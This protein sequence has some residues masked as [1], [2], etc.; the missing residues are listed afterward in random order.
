MTSQGYKR[1]QGAYLGPEIFDKFLSSE[2]RRFVRFADP[3][4]DECF[5]DSLGDIIPEML[6]ILTEVEAVA[7]VSDFF[8]VRYN[9]VP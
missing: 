7:P 5:P 9:C 3:T 2:R 6:P 4:F 8:G 1:T